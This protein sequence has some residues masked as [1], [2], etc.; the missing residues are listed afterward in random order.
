MKQLEKQQKKLAAKGINVNLDELRRD[1]ENQKAGGKSTLHLD[2][3]KL[4][5]EID[6]VGLDRSD[7][8]ITLKSPD[9]DL[10]LVKKHKVSPFSIESL[11]NSRVQ[12]EEE[13]LQLRRRMHQLVNNSHSAGSDG[14]EDNYVRNNNTKSPS[15]AHSPPPPSTAFRPMRTSSPSSLSPPPPLPGGPGVPP[16]GP[17][18]RRLAQTRVHLPERRRRRQDLDQTFADVSIPVVIAAGTKAELFASRCGCGYLRFQ[19]GFTPAVGASSNPASD[20]VDPGPGGGLPAVVPA[21]Q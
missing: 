20:G 4:D 10:S 8:D 11:L 21:I 13:K 1:Y 7:D 15:C 6:V 5:E 16:G 18:R 2:A 3:Q 17:R 12:E 9:P 14:E 19:G